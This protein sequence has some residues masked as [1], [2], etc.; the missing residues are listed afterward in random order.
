MVKKFLTLLVQLKVL[1]NEQ[2]VESLK[3]K[4]LTF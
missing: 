3:T 4:I 2:N 1:G